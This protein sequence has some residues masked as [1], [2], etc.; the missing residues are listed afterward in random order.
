MRHSGWAVIVAALC[1]A[2]GCVN[3]SQP[4][5]TS[6]STASVS[7][8]DAL[9]ASGFKMVPANPPERQ[10]ALRQLPPQKVVRQVRNDKVVFVYADPASCSCL[11]VGNATAYGAYRART[12]NTETADERA[13]N[14]WDWSPWTFGFPDD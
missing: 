11:Y 13:M 6:T 1:L 12:S 3:Q 4:I 10:T 7:K 14:N 8:T 5:A 9:I 2:A